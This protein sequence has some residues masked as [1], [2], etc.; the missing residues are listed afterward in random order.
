[1]P[2]FCLPR[3]YRFNVQ[4]KNRVVPAYSVIDNKT[5]AQGSVIDLFCR[6]G[7]E[8]TWTPDDSF[9]TTEEKHG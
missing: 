9:F 3:L 8:Q 7:E 5:M 1:M 4:N 6:T 2:L